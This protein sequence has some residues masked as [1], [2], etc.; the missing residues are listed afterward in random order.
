MSEK[1]S[2]LKEGGASRLDK[3][4]R[5]AVHI[6]R[7]AGRMMLFVSKHWLALV[8]IVVGLYALLPFASPL[9]Y[10]LGYDGMGHFIQV[11]YR[12]FC[13]QLP[14]RSYFLFGDRLVY[15]ANDLQSLVGLDAL[16][17]HFVCNETLGFKVA[18]CQRDV[19]IYTTMFVA[20]LLFAFFRKV[21]PITLKALVALSL[22]MGIDGFGQLFGLWT[23]TWLTRTITGFLFGLG[24]VL[25]V[26]PYAQEGMVDAYEQA[27]RMVNSEQQT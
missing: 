19:A 11:I 5:M 2:V 26:Y 8:N 17:Q 4:A 10:H 14:E 9:F 6:N 3:L 22:P 25:L 18:Y 20:G 12:P 15:S 23:S 21:R 13:H 24:V 27:A 7:F 16:T 1:N